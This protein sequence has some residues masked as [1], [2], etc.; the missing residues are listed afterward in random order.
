V[1]NPTNRTLKWGPYTD[2]TP[3]VLT[4]KVSGPSA[5]YAL[6]GQGSFDGN[7]VAVQGA[8]AVT[9]DLTTMPVVATPVITPTPN[10]VFPVD[11]TISC[12]T[13]GAVIHFTL[14]GTPATESSPVYAGPI[15][16]VTTAIVQAKAFRS[17]S[18]P[19]GAITVFYGD[20][21]R[22]AGTS[23]GRTV[24]ASGTPTPLIQ[25]AVQPARP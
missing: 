21:L 24:M 23:I 13:T 4:Y 17:W 11:V 6:A 19:S 2:A 8:T 10:G 1:W 18:V 9:V 14:D 5:T 7:P 3:R 22:A 20:E 25:I 16:L 12:V 15:H